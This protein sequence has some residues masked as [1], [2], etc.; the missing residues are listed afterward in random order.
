MGIDDSDSNKIK[1]IIGTP[2]NY[3][4]VLGTTLV[5]KLKA[6]P[7]T[8]SVGGVTLLNTTVERTSTS[9][10]PSFTKLKE[11]RIGRA[12][13]YKLLV[14]CIYYITNGKKMYYKVLKNGTDLIASGNGIIDYVDTLTVNS[15]VKNDIISLY[16]A[17]ETGATGN[18]GARYFDLKVDEDDDYGFATYSSGY[19]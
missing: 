2:T 6:E 15:L 18:M 11:I 12:G 7:Y 1:F 4:A 9:I 16:G 3:L 13:N 5:N 10:Y 8:A 19:D 17:V 14:E